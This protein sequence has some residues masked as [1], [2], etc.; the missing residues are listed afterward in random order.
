MWDTFLHNF[1][2]TTRGFITQQSIRFFLKVPK[3]D[4][5]TSKIFFNRPL[6]SM[7]IGFL[8]HAECAVNKQKFEAR[9]K[10]KVGHG[11]F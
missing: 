5:S 3:R 2:Y 10:L 9:P 11:C 7:F 1:N 8:P 6:I 4:V